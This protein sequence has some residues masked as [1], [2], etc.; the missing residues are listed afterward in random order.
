M[1]AREKERIVVPVLRGAKSL[2]GERNQRKDREISAL[3]ARLGTTNE[4]LLESQRRTEEEAQRYTEVLQQRA[5]QSKEGD[6][7][8]EQLARR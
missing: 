2:L 5:A 1:E 6:T 8:M 3:T 7:K 4:E